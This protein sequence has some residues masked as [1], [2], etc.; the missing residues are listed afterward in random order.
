MV[1]KNLMLL[2]T[3]FKTESY[4][5]YWQSSTRCIS[6]YIYFFI[7]DEL[8]EK[9]LMDQETLNIDMVWD[10][11]DWYKQSTLRTRCV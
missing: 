4:L 3:K 11:I 10:V 2:Q 9:V 5:I 7:G 6:I 1:S 8:F